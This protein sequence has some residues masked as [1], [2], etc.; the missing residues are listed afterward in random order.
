M[1]SFK[2]ITS[3]FILTLPLFCITSQASNL[4]SADRCLKEYQLNNFEQALALCL[5]AATQNNPQAQYVMG[6]LYKRGKA[7]KRS[8]AQAMQWLNSSADNGYAAAQLKFGK[9]ICSEQ[10]PDYGKAFGYFLRAAQ[11]NLNEAQFLVALCY[12]NGLG[13]TK[14]PQQALTWYNKAISNGLQAPD[15]PLNQN[16]KRL[17]VAA[18]N[19][20]INPSPERFA[21]LKSAA[22]QGEALAQFAVAM[23]YL[24]GGVTAQ[25]DAAALN[26]LQKAAEQGNS[27]A[28]SYLAWMHIMG[29]GTPQ[30]L[31]EAIYWFASNYNTSEQKPISISVDS[32]QQAKDQAVLLYKQ[33]IKLMEDKETTTQKQGLNLLIHSAKNNHL[34]AQ[35]MLAKAYHEGKGTAQSSSQAAQWFEKAAQNGSSEAQYALGWLYFNGEGVEKDITLSYYWF[36][37]AALYGG[38]KAK[39]AKNFVQ[40]YM[41]PANKTPK[42]ILQA[43][44]DSVHAVQPPKTASNF[45]QNIWKHSPIKSKENEAKSTLAA[46]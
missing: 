15:I 42:N 21:L 5:P 17:K 16:A 8:Q 13:V 12:Q 24:T 7:V 20:I 32:E 6:M 9:M 45:F 14:N 18:K 41:T 38:A 10:T 28:K 40:E 39:S 23:Y 25:D 37:K 19:S 31:Q 11:Q 36:D 27:D 3:A 35:L 29:L 44:K 33:A 2:L 1:R 26:Y 34:P 43:Y 4:S 30:N 22:D 46:K